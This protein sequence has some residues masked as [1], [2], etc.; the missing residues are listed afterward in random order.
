MPEDATRPEARRHDLRRS[1]RVFVNRTTRRVLPAGPAKESK[2]TRGHESSSMLRH[3]NELDVPRRVVSLQLLF[4]LMTVGLLSA[5][6][7]QV[8]LALQSRQVDS[9]C[10]TLIEKATPL[11]RADYRHNQGRRLQDIVVDL[12][13]DYSLESFAL[14][15]TDNVYIAHSSTSNVGNTA[16]DV[17][18][19]VDRW[20]EVERVLF[21]NDAGQS[22]RLFRAPL[23]D[24]D[25]TI[26]TLHVVVIDRGWGSTMMDALVVGIWPILL[27]VGCSVI[28]SILLWR[29]LRP[30]AGIE[31]QLRYSADAEGGAAAGL[32]PVASTSVAA[33]G[34]N[35]LIE[36]KFRKPS[37]GSVET[38][39]AAGLVAHREKKAETILRSL[40]DGVAMTDYDDRIT[41]VNSSFN[42]IAGV[43]EN[44][45][46]G[47][48]MSELF[49]FENSEAS[50]RF[51]DP[52]CRSQ[53]VIAEFD[54]DGDLAKG[55][56][57]IARAPL[58]NTQTEPTPDHVWTVRDV[59]QQKLADQM[60]SQFV[61]SATHELRTPL[62]NIKAYAETLANADAVDLEMQKDFCNTI[63]SEAT[64]LARFIDDLLNISRMEGGAM[65]LQKHDTDLARLF[66]EALAKV[67]PEIDAK[68]IV[69]ETRI[70]A[71]LPKIQVDKDKLT[72]TLVNLLGNAAKYTPEGGRVGFEVECQSDQLQIHVVDTGIGIAPDELAKVFDKFFRSA[73]PRVQ[74]RIGTGLGLAIANEIVRLH[75]GRILTHSELDKGSKFTVALPIGPER[76]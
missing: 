1:V 33:I 65:A 4:A 28:G 38:K 11:L 57:R 30:L 5:G 61:Y 31:A 10:R 15:G 49:H 20:G 69:L 74:D 54:R 52:L 9:L 7:V 14:V 2:L 60:R 73:D 66:E 43:T 37:L 71:K 58:L 21:T 34:W 24:G 23:R 12:A 29:T 46:I 44:G 16:E 39:V 19:A 25:H 35:R 17:I 18:G 72:V 6:I 64:R 50:A 40:P 63:N 3:P 47:R 75:G 56:L 27:G 76:S 70:P 41:F 68:G 36:E 62:S 13:A 32:M 53:Q 26:A 8:V 55:V 22:V 67:R 42:A 51:L 45:A 48:T 59:T